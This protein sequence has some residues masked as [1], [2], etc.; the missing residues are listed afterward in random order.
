MEREG[1]PGVFDEEPDFMRLYEEEEDELTAFLFRLKL[2]GISFSFQ[3]GK[4]SPNPPIRI[5]EQTE[6]D[7]GCID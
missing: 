1:E 3:A 2:D 6:M 5:V 7:L 4:R